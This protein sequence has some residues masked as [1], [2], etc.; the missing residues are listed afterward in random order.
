M[1][2][3]FLLPTG[4]IFVKVNATVGGEKWLKMLNFIRF[5]QPHRR[6]CPIKGTHLPVCFYYQKNHTPRRLRKE[7]NM[8]MRMISKTSRSMVYHRPECRY[9]QKM[10]KRNRVKMDRHV[11]EKLG[12]RPCKCCNSMIFR[13]RLELDDIKRF[14]KE[15][16]LDVDLKNN[17]I[18]ARTDVGCWK[19]HYKKERQI[20]I[21]FHRN[22]VKGRISLD[23][24]ERVPYHR[25]RDVAEAGSIIK[26][27]KYRNKHDEFK[28]NM[29]ADYRQMPQKTRKQREYYRSAKR[30]AE[31][32]YARR[33]DSLFFLIE[34]KEGIKSLSFC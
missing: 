10:Y 16:N 6:H 23:E 32:R 19:I 11:A 34:Q 29:P 1:V 15:H 20:F 13:Y 14:A 31:K 26:Y 12:Y 33:L 8:G 4:N 7:Q 21:L 22:Y 17:E 28:Q 27:L 18:Y 30:R 25:Q 3:D 9:A 2:R 24:V 5:F